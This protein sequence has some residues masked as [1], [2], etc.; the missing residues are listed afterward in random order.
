MEISHTFLVKERAVLNNVYHSKHYRKQ[1]EIRKFFGELFYYEAMKC[2]VKFNFVDIVV[3]HYIVNGRIPD[4]GSAWMVSKAGID[5]ICKA[6]VL[7]D[8][9]PNYVRSIKFNSPIKTD[10]WGVGISFTEVDV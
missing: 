9:N 1:A 7:P 2:K 6:G 4:T 10:F 3:D 5:F 8:D